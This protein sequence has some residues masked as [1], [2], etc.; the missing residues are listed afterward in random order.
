MRSE[1]HPIVKIPLR[2]N[3]EEGGIICNESKSQQR[4]FWPWQKQRN[5]NNQMESSCIGTSKGILL[6]ETY[7]YIIKDF[8]ANSKDTR[9]LLENGK[10]L[11]QLMP[12]REEAIEYAKLPEQPKSF[13]VGRYDEDRRGMYTSSLF[14][15][16]DSS[17]QRTIHV[18][19]DIGAP[20]GTPVYAFESG[21]IHS[22]GYNP[23]LGDYGHVIVIEHKLKNHNKVYALYGHLSAKTIQGKTAGQKVKRG[24]AIGYLGN[25]AENGGWTGTHVHFQLAVNPPPTHD[26]PGVVA[27][28]DRDKALLEYV[29]PRYVCGELY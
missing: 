5:R 2:T 6:N 24:Q 15:V 20:I 3:L 9:V 12:S 19:L 4:T 23:E 13:D 21:T 25:T 22:V 7:D 11:P 1:F 18:G 26:M 16:K 29:D 27:L 17:K 8:T 14:S 28:V 10:R